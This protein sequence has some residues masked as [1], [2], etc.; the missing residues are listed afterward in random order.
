MS[1]VIGHLAIG[2]ARLSL[3]NAP[4][5]DYAANHVLLVEGYDVCPVPE[6]HNYHGQR[7]NHGSLKSGF[8]MS[9]PLVK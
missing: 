5:S 7:R 2:V 9:R 3:M 1:S 8:C 4:V 6:T